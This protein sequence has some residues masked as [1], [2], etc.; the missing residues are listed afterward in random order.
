V[1]S[2][3]SLIHALTATRL[4]LMLLAAAGSAGLLLAALVFQAF[5]IE[6]CKLCWWQRYPHYAAVAVGVLALAWRPSVLL[7]WSGAAAAAATAAIGIYHTGVERKFWAGPDTCTAGA[8]NGQS[9]QDLLSQIMAAPLIRCDEVAW[10]LF[11]ISMPSWNAI[12]SL[13]LMAI[14][15]IAAR[16]A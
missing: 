4:R 16:R 12:A 9:A 13:G 2:I 6:P 10:A 3:R 7:A 5:G 15:I 8:L 1:N 14:W 11:G